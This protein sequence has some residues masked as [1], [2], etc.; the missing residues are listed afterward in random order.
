MTD[1]AVLTPLLEENEIRPKTIHYFLKE[2]IRLEN[3][4][5]DIKHL[6]NSECIECK[7]RILEAERFLTLLSISFR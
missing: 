6:T 5:L 4:K 1:P 2:G 3:L 7:V